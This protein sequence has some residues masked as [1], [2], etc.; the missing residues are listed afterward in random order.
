MNETKGLT[1][2]AFLAGTAAMGAMA[3]LTGCAAS[4]GKESTPVNAASV[5]AGKVEVKHVWCSMCGPAK[6][7]CSK[8]AYLKDGV[9]VNVEGN[10]S[11]GNNWGVGSKS[12]CVKA[13]AAMQTINDP[14]R[15]MYP[16]KR[17]GERGEGKFER[18]TWDE[19]MKL[20]TDA[21]KK[22]QDEGRPQDLG[23][24]SPQFFGVLAT[25]GR[26]FLNVFHSPNYMHSAICA[27]QRA[28]TKRVT[29]GNATASGPMGKCKLYVNWGANPE[30]SAQ[31]QGNPY[32]RVR[33]IE[34]G[35]QVID[36]RPMMD[37]LAA[38]A[39][40]WVPI[41]PGTDAALALGILNYII[42]NDL[43]DKEFC[44]Q[45]I[46]GFDKL[47]EHVKQFSLEWASEKTGV[48][49]ATIEKVAQMMG[50]IKPMS[51][52]D[53]NGVGDQQNDGTAGLQ[54]ILA[55]A[56]VT[57]NLYT[58]ASAA[59]AIKTKAI[60]ILTDRMPASEE[61]IERG[62][63][64]GIANQVSPEFPRWYSK[65]GFWETGGSSAYF[66]AITSPL[67]SE[68]PLRVIIGQCSNPF[69]ATRQ[70]KKVA[71]AL[72]K[73]DFYVVMDQFYNT[74]CDYAD[75]IFPAASHYEIS[76]QIGTKNRVDGTF[77][78][79]T[80]PIQDPP[81][82]C[83]SD[84][85]FYLDLGVAMG[86]GDD[87]W[88]GDMDACLAEQLEGSGITLDQLREYGELFVKA[89][90]N[91]E[92]PPA[93]SFEEAFKNLPN[94]KFQ[95]YNE[96]IGGK[97]SVWAG[98]EFDPGELHYLPYYQGPVE[99]LADTPE[100]AAEY[101]LIISDVHAY[102]LCNH[103]Y[104]SSVPYL[105][106]HQ[107]YPW[108][109]MNPETSKK[110]GIAEGDWVK[111]E[112]PH[113]WCVMKAEFFEGLSPETLM[114][115]RGWWQSCKE[116]DLPGYGCMDGGSDPSL[117]YA[118]DMTKFDPFTSAMAKQ[119]LVKISKTEAPSPWVPAVSTEE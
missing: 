20:F 39:T 11:A 45:W 71:E 105:R 12:L 22:L 101:P 82:E 63:Y 66:K 40:V 62:Y 15:I 83:K 9:W 55:I 13:Q 30:N 77:I 86:Y 102:R 59:P 61:D 10:P 103:S 17:V 114:A 14:L 93:P 29:I 98:T 54:A 107:P 57:G 4:S 18:C 85:Q 72:M 50:T 31:N 19:G 89:D 46:N 58:S 33:A 36:I 38:K 68:N 3:A 104:Y 116:L 109:R 49:V 70:P 42:S 69:G 106:E 16:M 28:M 7:V 94:K 88:G 48:D 41:R 119:T 95:G 52:V 1:R 90:P 108:V 65:P 78:G 100:I 117:L 87:F 6:T 27:M 32:S 75:V 84:W 99:S 111:I 25:V 34:N 56:A 64:A 81:G 44:E 43:H 110:Y 76:H 115:R 118:T 80:Q 37:Q 67:W 5:E 24:L 26:R 73:L 97:P 53:G 91:A 96:F 23:I 47:A 74:S 35:M 60:D 2:R 8:Y 51:I 92:K 112:S 79:I 113:G 21:L